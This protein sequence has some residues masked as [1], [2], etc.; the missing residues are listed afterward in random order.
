MSRLP[1]VLVATAVC[2]QSQTA[3]HPRYP[4]APS[5]L[6]SRD[7]LALVRAIL[8]GEVRVRNAAMNEVFDFRVPLED[9]TLKPDL[10]V[11]AVQ[12]DEDS[13]FE[14][15]MTVH[16][17]PPGLSAVVIVDRGADGWRANGNSGYRWHWDPNTAEQVVE[18]HPPFVM[19]RETGGGTGIWSTDATLFRLWRGR[20][21]KTFAVTEGREATRYGTDPLETVLETAKLTISQHEIGVR[22]EKTSL[23]TDGNGKQVRKPLTKSECKAYR[24]NLPTLTFEP[25]AKVTEVLCRSSR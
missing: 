5:R 16:V 14:F 25:D 17:G 11:N 9:G 4:A 3:V 6:L 12:L 2:L 8:G 19:V 1:L 15:V 24:W 21:Y 20:L 23:F 13:E 10:T 7:P 22:T 18:L